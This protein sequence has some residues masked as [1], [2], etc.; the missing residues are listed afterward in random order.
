MQ[1]ELG[2]KHSTWA[3]LGRFSKSVQLANNIDKILCLLCTVGQGNCH[4]YSDINVL[5]FI[6]CADM[7]L[8]SYNRYYTVTMYER[9]FSHNSR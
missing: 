7:R 2:R 5:L 4:A 8:T 3:G 6:K 9:L 1:L